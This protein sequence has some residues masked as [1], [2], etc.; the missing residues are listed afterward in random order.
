[1]PRPTR[2]HSREPVAELSLALALFGLALILLLGLLTG[3]C[4]EIGPLLDAAGVERPHV[5]VEGTRLTGLSFDAAELGVTFRIDNPNDVG[6]RLAGLDYAVDVAGQTVAS[7]DR[8]RSLTIRPSDSQTLELPITVRYAD[9]FRLVR[10]LRE[11]RDGGA[12]AGYALRTGFLFDLPALGRVRVPVERRGDLPLVRRPSLSLGSLRVAGLTAS[13]ARL[14]VGLEVD[15]PNG[16]A[17]DLVGADLDLVVE[18]DRWARVGDPRRGSVRSRGRSTLE[19]PVEVDFASLGRGA[20]RLLSG[21]R[22]VDVRLAGTVTFDGSLPELER[23]RL[24]VDLAA[25]VPVL[26]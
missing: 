14:L 8:N 23:S 5:S 20:E 2:P 17:L 24:P 4:A 6:V 13:G 25:S 22:S 7:G 16:F 19:V 9:V 1:M 3:G 18:G 10:T 21:G 15:N 11:G 26:R 12:D